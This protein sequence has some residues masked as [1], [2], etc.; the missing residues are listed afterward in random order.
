MKIGENRL[1]VKAAPWVRAAINDKQTRI[2]AATGGLGSGKTHGGAQWFI[3]RCLVNHESQKSAI[4]APVHRL[5]KSAIV[6]NIQKALHELEF[7]EG[8]DYRILG[9]GG[10]KIKLKFS[11][12]EIYLI[13]LRDPNMVVADEFSHTWIDEAAATKEGSLSKVRDRTRDPKAVINQTLVTGAPQGVTGWFAE[14]FD[15][16]TVPGWQER[17]QLDYVNTVEKF[18][19]FILETEKNPNIPRSYVE[20]LK[21][22]YRHN[23]NHIRLWLMGRFAPLSEGLVFSNYS[24]PV[25]DVPDIDPHPKRD[26]VLTWDFNAAPVSWVA[27][28]LFRFE[29]DR[30]KRWNWTALHNADSGSG[31]LDEAC[32]EFSKKFPKQEFSET[33]IIIYGDRTGHGKS[34]KIKGSDY[35]NIRRYLNQLGYKHV[36]IRAARALAL[37]SDTVQALQR[38]F[39]ENLIAVCKRCQV[40]RTSLLSTA[41]KKGTRDIDK[42]AGETWTHAVEA[43]KYFA[44]QET[45][46][47]DGTLKQTILQ[48]SQV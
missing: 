38:L 24:Q 35:D 32:I 39:L 12:Q 41:Y 9:G 21:R 7:S 22:Q 44:W 15:S 25:H 14:N 47:F 48:S 4:F 6:P 10:A 13:T 37:T 30:G 31:D 29:T 46:H 33:R 20:D 23:Q 8:S 42:P 26:I 5:L 43:L 1:I 3:N 28:Q 45:L 34:H 18:R 17:A 11:G 19:R 36:E 16:D 40:L 27:L 2:F